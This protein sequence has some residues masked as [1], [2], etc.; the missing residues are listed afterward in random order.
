MR[1][2]FP[3][4]TWDSLCLY[5]TEASTNRAATSLEDHEW[6]G[7]LE[8]I[9][10]DYSVAMRKHFPIDTKPFQGTLTPDH[11][12]V[13]STYRALM[14]FFPAVP[15]LPAPAGGKANAF[16]NGGSPTV[17]P[18]GGL[19]GG[20]AI[21]GVPAADRVGPIPGVGGGGTAL[22]G[23]DDGGWEESGDGVGTVDGVDGLGVAA[24][25]GGGGAAFGAS[26]CP[27]GYKQ[28]GKPKRQ[29]PATECR[30]T[31]LTPFVTH[32]FNSLS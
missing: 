17:A 21:P 8:T 22:G 31:P 5:S 3:V 2:T 30:A 14:L 15:F 13:I 19:E 20:V 10:S 26:G 24:A 11:H 1:S 9:S 4:A 12:Y 27:P 23:R 7:P 6:E 29:P 25:R 32:R 28:T 18:D 16:P